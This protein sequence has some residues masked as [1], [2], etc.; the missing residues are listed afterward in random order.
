MIK[1]TKI[2]DLIYNKII[3]KLESILINH[4]FK[5]IKSKKYFIRKFNDYEH[6]IKINP[7]SY[8]VFI[9]FEDIESLIL[10]FNISF[11]INSRKFEV[12]YENKTS[13]K[14][15]YSQIVETIN[16]Y[17]NID[18]SEDLERNDYI[19]LK[20][21][22]NVTVKNSSELK[23][24]FDLDTIINSVMVEKILKIESNSTNIKLF[25]LSKYPMSIASISLL[26]YGGYNE[27]AISLINSRHKIELEELLEKKK[28]K[29]NI[30]FEVNQLQEHLNQ[31]NK[32]TG[33][34]LDNPYNNE[35]ECKLGSDYILSLSQKSNYKEI[36]KVSKPNIKISHHI[37][38]PIN[39]E[40]IIILDNDTVIKLNKN[41]KKLLEF[42]PENSKGYTST[43]H[44]S[45]GLIKDT[46]YFFVNNCIISPENEIFYILQKKWNKKLLTTK[47]ITYSAEKKEYNVHCK[48]IAGRVIPNIINCTLTDSFEVKRIEESINN[49][50]YISEVIPNIKNGKILIS[51]S[52]NYAL[53]YGSGTKSTIIDIQN[54]N[55][56][57]IYAHPTSVKGYIE[58]IYP[59]CPKNFDITNAVFSDNDRYLIASS[60]YG[61]VT[62][63]TLPNFERV[64]LIPNENFIDKLEYGKKI[65]VKDTTFFKWSNGVFGGWIKE[66]HTFE[67][68][69]LFLTQTEDTTLIW[70]NDFENTNIIKDLGII[71][72][73]SD[74]YLTQQVNNELIIYEL[75]KNLS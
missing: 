22:T 65:Q 3:L 60:Y 69:D 8:N 62:A 28:S 25:E 6:V 52:K 44:F 43:W 14:I 46:N 10:N 51:R 38:N 17:I 49:Q 21:N 47:N 16:G 36:L 45:C 34:V 39:G 27:K 50:D 63:W 55:K 40:F 59:N 66:I 74:N 4:D 64:E 35:I 70:N 7:P 41:G 71:K 23:K 67:K 1:K 42:K 29:A 2:N 56:K 72:L 20:R 68:S 73:H 18:I 61:K 54:K 57:N 19:S 33:I 24:D 5:F 12:W 32:L 13:K 9:Y 11:S 75:N 31:I 15:N 53:W 37:L 58:N 30:S 48:I 26:I